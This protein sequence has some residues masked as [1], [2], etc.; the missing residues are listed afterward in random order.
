MLEPIRTVLADDEPLARRQLRA[1]LQRD[2]QISLVAVAQD[3]SPGLSKLGSGN[4]RRIAETVASVAS[5]LDKPVAFFNP[6]A[7]GF[8][9]HVIEP[10]EGTEVA[11]MQGTRA[12]L[13]AI[14]RLFEYT[15]FR[16]AASPPPGLK[17]DGTWRK[18]LAGGKPLTDPSFAK[19]WKE[20]DRRKLPVLVHPSAP[21]GTSEMG[22]HEF[23][24][25]APIGFTFDTSLA[26]A[27]CIYDGFFDRY[28]NLKMILSHGGGAFPY[29]SGR[30][31]LMHHRMD[32]AA[33]GDV[34]VEAPSAY[35][36]RMVYDSIVHSPK[37][38]R[39]L[40]DLV[41]LD[42]VALGTDYS[43]PPADMEPLALLRAAGLSKA[44][45]E[46]IADRNPRR[47]FARMK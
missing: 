41:G 11:V 15:A 39:F 8:H 36:P 2:P 29:L 26:G 37:V 47:L 22:L 30:F 40:I 20:I 6:T 33:Q 42:N 25:T 3:C 28:P 9:P 44:D 24:L 17:V 12:S 32:R 7:G 35:A 4:Y 31:D 38:L 14:R 46:A 34:A 23:Q 10:F 45:A 1:L 27:R 19:I 18:R 43:F 16:P 21:P 5:R 13:T